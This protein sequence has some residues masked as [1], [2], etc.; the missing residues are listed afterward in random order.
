MALLDMLK[1]QKKKK[2]ISFWGLIYHIVTIDE[3]RGD[4][5]YLSN[6]TYITVAEALLRLRLHER[7]RYFIYNPDNFIFEQID[8]PE[9]DEAKTFLNSLLLSNGEKNTPAEVIATQ[10]KFKN[11]FWLK[12]SLEQVFPEGT[13]N[14][15]DQKILNVGKHQLLKVSPS[16][17]S[18]ESI[19]DQNLVELQKQNKRLR[20][21]ISELE[22]KQGY[23]DR[24][25]KYFSIEMKLCHDAW[26]HLYM[27][28]NNSRLPHST[29]VSN[30]LKNLNNITVNTKAVGRIKTIT[31]PKRKLADRE[32]KEDI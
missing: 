17:I 26:N 14:L 7:V 28:E 23:L 30:Y 18:D 1:E 27:G 9:V 22:A 21:R 8:Q 16:W 29:Q 10:R 15:A 19:D 11:Y 12:E 3:D 31:N 32:E 4:E 25:N 6:E 5:T 13:I 24:N 20:E 2:Y